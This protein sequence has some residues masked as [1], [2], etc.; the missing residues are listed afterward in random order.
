MNMMRMVCDSTYIIDQKSR[1]D[2]KVEELMN[3]IEEIDSEG[4]EKVVVFSQWQRMTTII[5]AELDKKDIKYEYLHDTS[6][7]RTCWAG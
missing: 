6:K 2:T 7:K 1:N 3:I 4:S 5:A